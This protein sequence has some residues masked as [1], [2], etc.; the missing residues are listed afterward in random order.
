MLVS[1]VALAVAILLIGVLKDQYWSS[2]APVCVYDTDRML[3]ACGGAVDNDGTGGSLSG[4]GV[5]AIESGYSSERQIHFFKKRGGSK[6]DAGG[7]PIHRFPALA[8]GILAVFRQVRYMRNEPTGVAMI[9]R[10]R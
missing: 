9:K 7:V 8:G 3:P 5:I 2:W 1:G 6:Q 10:W 4:P